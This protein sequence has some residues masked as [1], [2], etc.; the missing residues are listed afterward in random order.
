MDIYFK[1]IFKYIKIIFSIFFE[2]F[3][4]III[5]TGIFNGYSISN[6]GSILISFLLLIFALIL[7][8]SNEAFQ[9]AAM[10]V[11]DMD[12]KTIEKKGYMRTVKIHK[13]LFENDNKLSKLFIGQS[14][15]VVLCSFV[16]ASVTTFPNYTS[17]KAGTSNPIYLYIFYS[18]GLPG[19]FFTVTIAQLLPSIFAKKNPLITLNIP[20]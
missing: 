4:I 16:I 17:D 18:S 14:F 2:I 10:R 3:S 8:A 19:V 7:L 5:C 9:V 6:Y 12:L 13:L 15:I 1:L 20:G 11:K